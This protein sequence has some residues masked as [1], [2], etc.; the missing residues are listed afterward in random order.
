M[1]PEWASPPTLSLIAVAWQ[2]PRAG[3]LFRGAEQPAPFASRSI[4]GS[5]ELQTRPGADHA[6]DGCHDDTFSYDMLAE[7]G[8]GYNPHLDRLRAD[9]ASYSP[10][11]P[12]TPT[13]MIWC[14]PPLD[15]L[16]SIDLES[17]TEVQ[18]ATDRLMAEEVCRAT[19]LDAAAMFPRSGSIL[20]ELRVGNTC[21]D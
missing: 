7:L 17:H 12:M 10:T 5:L 4:F 2:P 14:S 1:S 6:Q 16:R 11:H 9:R 13:P 21:V 15:E 8:H 20:P 3:L 18:G 19:S